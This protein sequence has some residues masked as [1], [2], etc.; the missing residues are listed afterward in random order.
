MDNSKVLVASVKR[1]C[2]IVRMT[3][4]TIDLTPQLKKN[5]HQQVLWK[6]FSHPTG[7]EIEGDAIYSEALLIVL[8]K[9]HCKKK[10]TG[11]KK[12]LI[13]AAI[14]SRTGGC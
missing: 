14:D 4:E 12:F 2:A 10:T 6:L 7:K 8:F 9:F 3:T 11:K 5:F 13:A 1:G